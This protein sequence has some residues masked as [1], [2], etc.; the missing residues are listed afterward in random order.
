MLRKQA[1]V[2]VP[3]GD[4]EPSL[5]EALADADG[6]V[7][8]G[9]ARLTATLIDASPRLRV[10]GAVGSGTDNIDV[11]AA[12]AR[13]IRIVHG[14]GVA[15]RAVAEFVIGAMV[16]GH[17]NFP[18]LDRSVRD[19]DV[20]WPARLVRFR[21]AELT[22]STLGVI[23]Y[24]NIGRTVARLAHAAFDARV[25]AYDPFLADDTRI[26]GATLVRDLDTLLEASMTVTVHVPLTDD[27]RGLLGRGELR[28]IGPD[29]VLIDTARGGIVDE[30]ALVDALRA[31]EL[32]AAVL[33]VFDGEPP[34]R[35][36][37]DHLASAP[38]L[39]LSP[40]VAGMTDQAFERLS[41][42][43]AGGVLELLVGT[44]ATRVYDPEGR[45]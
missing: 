25:L 7:I 13:G 36:Q 8:R 38:N 17:R 26:G 37:I 2:V 35:H 21:A 45:N 33:D 12:T 11:A 30:P 22:G 5:R 18:A 15:P 27:T 41:V 16:A 39:L 34:S 10:I 31:G 19:L 42:N 32:K 14:A 4:D 24:G 9:P 20:D 6:I 29:G 1:D 40:H 43:V 44:P 3:R 23:G 28:R